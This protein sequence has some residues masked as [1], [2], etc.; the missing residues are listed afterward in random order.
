[1]EWEPGTSKLRI[2]N[3]LLAAINYESASFDERGRLVCQPYL[4]PS[5]RAA[6]YVYA[7]DEWSPV[8]GNVDQTLDLFDVPNKWVLVKSEADQAPLTS[9]YVNDLP[10]SPTSTVSR[11]RAS[12][13]S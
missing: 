12:S 2:L 10:S 3:D 7:A 1:M 4:S 8:T 5:A 13:A 11:G 6:S 9:V